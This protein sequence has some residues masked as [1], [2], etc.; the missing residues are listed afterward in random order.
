MIE[1]PKLKII[2]VMMTVLGCVGP[3]PVKAGAPMWDVPADAQDALTYCW[4]SR[5]DLLD[6][7][8]SPVQ[9]VAL[10]V[11]FECESLARDYASEK[12]AA[13]GNDV[14]P[15]EV[16]NI[17][18]AMRDKS[19]PVMASKV[20]SSRAKVGSQSVTY[21]ADELHSMAVAQLLATSDALDSGY[22]TF[23]RASSAF[24]SQRATCDL[25]SS[26][27]LMGL[28]IGH[29]LAVRFYTQRAVAMLN[30]EI[31]RDSPC[32]ASALAGIR[33]MV[34]ESRP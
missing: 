19:L 21:S 17:V 5:T 1:T 30:D 23:L 16:K 12:L 28:D 6:D 26:Y 9:V 11:L 31:A 33:E 2:A 32:A 25:A 29:V 14:D 34:N 15:D 18:N 22:L 27:V 13:Y 7:G 10:A 24:G 8:V 3:L 4:A 20:L